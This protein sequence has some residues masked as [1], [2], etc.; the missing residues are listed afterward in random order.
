MFSEFAPE[1]VER[2]VARVAL[3]CVGVRQNFDLFLSTI[4]LVGNLL[5]GRARQKSEGLLLPVRYRCH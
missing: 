3:G 1:R 4:E 5:T 2:V